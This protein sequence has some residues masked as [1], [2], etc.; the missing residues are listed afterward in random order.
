MYIVI[1][2][3][4]VVMVAFSVT[5][6]FW[7]ALD[8]VAD[9]L[10]DLFYRNEERWWWEKELPQAIGKS[11]FLTRSALNLLNDEG[12]LRKKIILINA[13]RTYSQEGRMYYPGAMLLVRIDNGSGPRKKK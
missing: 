12:R 9:D 1:F 13:I 2:V 8:G 5:R 6:V 10:I 4:A 3:M 11:G 7:R